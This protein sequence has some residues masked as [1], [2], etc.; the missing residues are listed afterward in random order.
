MP[1]KT[2]I[3]SAY[4]PVL[5]GLKLNKNVSSLETDFFRKRKEAIIKCTVILIVHDDSSPTSCFQEYIN[6]SNFCILH[7][8][9]F[10][11]NW[12]FSFDNGHL[13]FHLKTGQVIEPLGVYLRPFFHDR[14]SKLRELCLHLAHALELW[15]GSFIGPKIENVNNGS[16][17]HQLVSTI[18]KARELSNCKNHSLTPSYFIKGNSSKINDLLQKH[19]SLIV[20]SCSG[21]RSRVVSEEEFMKWDHKNLGSVPVLFQ[22]R[23]PGKDVRVHVLDDQIWAVQVKEKKGVDYRYV[24][25]GDYLAYPLTT[26]QKKFCFS[27]KQ[28]ENL[29]LVGIDLLVDEKN[30]MSCLECNPNPGWAGFHRKSKD[31]HLLVESLY[32][33]ISQTE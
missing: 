10:C 18:K 28:L 25:R 24:E 23:M 4:R 29:R 22:K 17:A 30:N 2:F 6:E 3:Q 1:K 12:N 21:I 33:K 9:D 19:N 15:S 20:K 27:L 32:N 26:E 14:P 8:D 7:Y 31:E 13:K 5:K 16:K 11:R